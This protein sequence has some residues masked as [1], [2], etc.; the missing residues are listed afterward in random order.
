MASVRLGLDEATTGD[1][2]MVCAICGDD[3]TEMVDRKLSAVR[4]GLLLIV[5]TRLTVI[6][7]YCSNHV[8][9]SWNAFMRVRAR[10]ISKTGITLGQVSQEFVDAVWDYRENPDRSKRLRREVRE[11]QDVEAVGDDDESTQRRRSSGGNRVLYAVLMTALVIVGVTGC[12]CGL[13]FFGLI[14]NA[15]SG[16][17]QQPGFQGPQGPGVPKAPF[18]K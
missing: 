7:P 13:L 16:G 17:R 9:A 10:S 12:G 6:L 4:P 2:P 15:P 14:R 18:R 8:V 5:R 11:I 1:L 3:A